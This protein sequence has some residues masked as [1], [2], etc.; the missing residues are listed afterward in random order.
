STRALRAVA[1]RRL[2]FRRTIL[3]AWVGA[4]PTDRV[5]RMAPGS[6]KAHG[7]TIGTDDTNTLATRPARIARTQA[8]STGTADAGVT[9]PC[10]QGPA[11]RRTCGAGRFACCGAFLGPS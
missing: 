11:R 2:S 3:T 4:A 10:W 1:K 8:E 5:C 7:L 9:S 6:V